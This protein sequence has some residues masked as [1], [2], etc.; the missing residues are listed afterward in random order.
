M[1]GRSALL[2]VALAVLASAVQANYSFDNPEQYLADAAQWRPWKDVLRRNSLDSDLLGYCVADLARCPKR[3]RGVATVI[4]KGRDLSLPDKLRLANRYV[5][6]R[7]Y[8]EDRTSRPALMDGDVH[9]NQWRPLL[10]T[11]AHGGDCEDFATAKYFLLREL[12]VPAD[13]MRVVVL[14]DRR[15]RD[16]HAMLAVDMDDG[17]WFLESDNTIQRD[18]QMGKY[19]FQYSL[20]E[21]GIWDHSFEAL[22]R[23]HGGES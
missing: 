6:K 14:W 2:G 10:E 17:V 5:N 9:R 3:Y 12:G 22:Q 4:I 11:L 8:R 19:E 20:N 15:A 16:F 23:T 18:W 7:R 1:G 21:Q 13:L